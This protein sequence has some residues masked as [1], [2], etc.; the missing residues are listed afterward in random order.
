VPLNEDEKDMRQNIFQDGDY[1]PG[2][3]GNI[4]SISVYTRNHERTDTAIP[5]LQ[6]LPLKQEKGIR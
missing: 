6:G 4:L 1:Y 3:I 5:V 2:D